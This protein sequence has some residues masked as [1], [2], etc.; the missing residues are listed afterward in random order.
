MI[1]WVPPPCDRVKVKFDASWSNGEAR[2]E[3]I[4]RDHR[5]TAMFVETIRTV[6]L[7]VPEAELVA[8]WNALTTAAYRLGLTRS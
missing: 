1:S 2:L 3:Y 5:G 4:I 7:S 8:A 6:A